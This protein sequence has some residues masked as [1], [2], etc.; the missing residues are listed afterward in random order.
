MKPYMD[1]LGIH[2]SKATGKVFQE[3]NMDPIFCPAYSPFANPIEEC[4]SVVK[5]AYKKAKLN[6]IMKETG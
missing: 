4:F 5:Q 2:R 6:E 1:N 3:L